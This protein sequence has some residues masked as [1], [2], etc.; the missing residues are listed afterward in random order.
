MNF[1]KCTLYIKT[2]KGWMEVG[3]I[4]NVTIVKTDDP[5]AVDLAEMHLGVVE[6]ERILDDA[7]D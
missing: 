1:G 4:T 5:N 2:E 7:K 3:E 6:A